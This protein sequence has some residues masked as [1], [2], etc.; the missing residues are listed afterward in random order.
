M[1]LRSGVAVAVVQAGSCS[2]DLT[3]SLG[4]ST[5]CRCG[6]KKERKKKNFKVD[7]NSDLQNSIH[8][9]LRSV[10]ED[11]FRDPTPSALQGEATR[12]RGSALKQLTTPPFS[13]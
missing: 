2:F 7:T 9:K 13:R 10:A 5:C 6:P 8:S 3:L 4:N 1:R 11:A 12:E